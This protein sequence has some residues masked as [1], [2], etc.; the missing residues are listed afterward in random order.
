[1]SKLAHKAVCT[2]YVLALLLHKAKV[3]MLLANKG[4]KAVF[5]DDDAKLLETFVKNDMLSLSK[6]S[7]YVGISAIL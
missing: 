3:P 1:M 5:S 2:L 4:S 6:L 7:R